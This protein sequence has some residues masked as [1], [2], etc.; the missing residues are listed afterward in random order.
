MRDDILAKAQRLRAEG[1]PFAL[2]TVVMARQPTSGA[3][4]ARAII[5]PDGQMEG[6]VGGHC[7][8]PT[9][10]RQGLEALAERTPRLVVLSPGEAGM[11]EE[12]REE[13]PGVIRAPMLCASQGELQVFVEPFLPRATVA[14]IGESAV[15]RALARFAALLDFEV[16]AC[17]PLAD[18]EMFP[19]T[20]RL[21]TSLEALAPQLTERSYVI[22]ATIGEYDEQA[23]EM[24]LASP[25]SYVGIIASKTRLKTVQDALL[26][27]GIPEERVALLKRPSGLP[28]LALTPEEIAF[29]VMAELIEA[30]RQRVGQMGDVAPTPQRA[31][32]IDPICGM[33]VDIATARYTTTRDGKTYYFCCA[34]CKRTFDAAPAA[35]PIQP[36]HGGHHGGE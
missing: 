5:L 31:E 24:A 15:A 11:A 17:D 22:I 34:G 8:R 7:A 9:V 23:A 28:G 20:D 16:W 18:M 3:A 10:M 33:T 14:I 32:A 27:Q 2:A 4:G 1:R 36:H 21:V 13:K 6:W 25:A 19:G 12:G 30:R 35:A 26:E 29:S